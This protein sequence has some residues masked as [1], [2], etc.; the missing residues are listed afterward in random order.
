M[1][2]AEGKKKKKTGERRRPDMQP[3]WQGKCIA[4]GASPIVPLTGLCGPCSF[5]EADT[6]GGNW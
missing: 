1:S 2:R 4:C 5:G 6:L 3:D